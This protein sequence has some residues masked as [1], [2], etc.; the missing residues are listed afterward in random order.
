MGT[1]PGT[2][3]NNAPSST[4]GSGMSSGSSYG[5]GSSTRAPRADRN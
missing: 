4:T 3:G 2:M 5:S 1:T